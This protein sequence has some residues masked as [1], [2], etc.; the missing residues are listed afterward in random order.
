[1]AWL[2]NIGGKLKSDYR[3]SVGICYN[4][5]PWP[6]A[7]EKAKAKIRSLAQAVLEVRSLHTGATLADLYDPDVM[8]PDLRKAHRALDMAVDKL[9]RASAFPSD[10]ERVEHLFGLYEKLVAPLTALASVKPK[11]ARSRQA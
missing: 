2:S 3:Y 4:P 1:M 8:P 7:D 11:K 5:F 6:E 9:Y 10:R